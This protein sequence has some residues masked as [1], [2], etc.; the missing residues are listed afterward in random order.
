MK[1]LCRKTTASFYRKVLINRL[2]FRTFGQN[3]KLMECII[4]LPP[5]VTILF[6]VGEE[7]S[8]SIVRYVNKKTGWVSIYE[9]EP[10]YDPIKKA[11][12]PKRKYIGYEDPVTKEFIPSSGKRGRKRRP[13]TA[14]E[15]DSN[16]AVDRYYGEYKRAVG[17]IEKLRQEK[18]QL[19]GEIQSLK[20]Q[21]VKIH[22]VIDSFTETV[23]KL[24]EQTDV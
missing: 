18:Q 9:S 15:S 24:K 6:S 12:R 19:L 3:T 1:S 20:K 21:L 2:Y 14:P 4:L 11:S 8:M 16:H 5:R 10:Y 22:S 7:I 23:S 17:E 13:E